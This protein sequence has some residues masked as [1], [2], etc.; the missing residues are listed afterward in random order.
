M[1]RRED[2]HCFYI[3]NSAVYLMGTAVRWLVL[4]A[5]LFV[6]DIQM[7]QATDLEMIIEQCSLLLL[8]SVPI[9]VVDWFPDAVERN[10]GS[11]VPREEAK[12]KK[13]FPNLPDASL[14]YVLQ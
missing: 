11:I 13:S 10:E 7:P 3:T 2:K 6:Q 9:R 14:K 4:N 1:Y 12:I 5:S 8:K